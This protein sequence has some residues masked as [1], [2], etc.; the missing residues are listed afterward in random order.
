MRLLRYL[1]EEYITSIKGKYS[2][3]TFE[4]YK[5]PTPK[6][7]SEL[8][9]VD[10]AYRYSGFRVLVD[11]NKKDV[12]ISN[13]N[14]I[15]EEMFKALYSQLK[16]TYDSFVTY[17]SSTILTFECVKDDMKSFVDSDTLRYWNQKMNPS[18]LKNLTELYHKDFSWLSKWFN[19]KE[20]KELVDEVVIYHT[21]KG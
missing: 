2:D 5:N 9:K 1:T 12:Y 17:G 10:N 4:I 8:K 21:R 16:T 15:H 6:E 20:V 3:G 13:N 18:V 11:F 14:I 19:V 7:I